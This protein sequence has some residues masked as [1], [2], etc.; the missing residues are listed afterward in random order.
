MAL[1]RVSYTLA[2]HL[3]LQGETTQKYELGTYKKAS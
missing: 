1:L 2:V 3:Q